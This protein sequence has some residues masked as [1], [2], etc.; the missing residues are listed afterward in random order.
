MMEQL[1]EKMY[2]HYRK[3]KAIERGFV[4]YDYGAYEAHVKCAYH[5]VKNLELCDDDYIVK[6]IV[7]MYQAL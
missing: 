6:N 7:K 5:Y 3:A 4:P 2:Q 1:M